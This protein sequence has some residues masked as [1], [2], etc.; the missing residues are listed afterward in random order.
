MAAAVVQ[1][2]TLEEVV[3]HPIEGLTARQMSTVVAAA[4]GISTKL[5]P[6]EV[7]VAG[8]EA[9][10]RKTH[11]DVLSPPAKAGSG[12]V[13][14]QLRAIAE[15]LL[16]QQ[17][18]AEDAAATR[19][20]PIDTATPDAD[21]ALPTPDRITQA[22]GE[23][24]GDLPATPTP[25]PSSSAPPTPD[26]DGKSTRLKQLLDP[27]EAAGFPRGLR[28]TERTSAVH[29]EFTA[30]SASTAAA[31]LGAADSPLPASFERPSVSDDDQAKKDV[32][33]KKNAIAVRALMLCQVCRSFGI[34]LRMQTETQIWLNA[35]AGDFAGQARVQ[36]NLESLSSMIGFVVS[37]VLGGLSDA[38]GRRPLML[39]SPCFSVATNILIVCS[40]TVPS[41]VVRRLLMPF[42]STPWHS[43]EAAA[44][45]DM[46]KGDPEGY[47]LAKS[48]INI[49]QSVMM[50]VC[51]ILGARLAAISLRLPWAVCGLS[52][53]L[54]IV[55]AYK[56]LRET[57]PE[58]ERVPFRWKGSNPL[59][60]IKLFQRGHKMRM[61]AIA[62]IWDG[63]CGRMATFRYEQLHQQNLL[64]WGMAERANFSS[65]RGMLSVPASYL[66]GWLL[67]N[68]GTKRSLMLGNLST[69]AEALCSAVAT[70]G[71][72]FYMI[73][74]LSATSETR[75]LAMAY[76]T[77]EV[78]N[79]CGFA[80]GEMQAALSNVKAIVNI[81]TP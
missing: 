39:M 20:A 68:I 4:L 51:P 58:E 37:P 26:R 23:I 38:I 79:A 57:L 22:V 30:G 41:L 32:Q 6:A 9:A 74:P 1:P 7:V 72:H 44:L 19:P 73:R 49:V 5:S 46:F 81:V 16:A 78:A 45:A 75:E 76:T 40:P 3:Q 12:G 55:V 64:G 31:E 14:E 15:A 17:K 25:P 35:F 21:D 53:S 34:M 48:R 77:T 70:R 2:L 65:Y 62:Q 52:F 59:S 50:I 27:T 18:V 60:F 10:M 28:K 43:G 13:K 11:E 47:S 69:S 56:Y 8:K 67:R 29:L 36:G 80:Q 66:S 24:M 42:S 61:L 63:M 71:A 54:M 33:A